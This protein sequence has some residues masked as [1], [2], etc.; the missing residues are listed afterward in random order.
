VTG[1]T[2]GAHINFFVAGAYG[3]TGNVYHFAV[4]LKAVSYG[5]NSAFQ[6][7]ERIV[8]SFIPAPPTSAGKHA[9]WVAAGSMTPSATGGCAS[10]ANIASAANQPDIQTLNFDST[11]QEYAQFSIKMPPSWDEGTLTFRPVWSHAATTTNFGV[12]WELQAVAVG[13]DDTIAVNYGTAVAVTDTGG[14]TNDQYTGDESAAITVAG[15]PQAGD[16]VY[17]RVS[18]NPS[19]G[20][21]TMAIDARLHGIEVYMTT[22]ASTDA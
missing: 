6:E 3:A 18:R 17:F 13:D 2:S 9:A 11:T 21:D 22:D 12:A 5:S 4:G 7:G 14:T 10:L 8:V 16:V 20:S 15:S 1:V 19:N